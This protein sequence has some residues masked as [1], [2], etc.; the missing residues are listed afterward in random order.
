[1][2]DQGKYA[3]D[4]D[5]L[6]HEYIINELKEFFVIGNAVEV[7]CYEGHMT[8]LLTPHFSTLTVVEADKEFAKKV[9]KRLPAV[10]AIH[11]RIEDFPLNRKFDNAF[12][13]HTL[14]HIKNDVEVLATL[15]NLL[16]ERGRLFVVVPNATAGSRQIAVAAGLIENPYGIT[17]SEREHGHLRTYDSRTLRKVVDDVGLKVIASGGIFF[18]ALANFQLDA[19]M[20]SG[21]I[22]EEYL[23]GCLLLSKR[24]PDLCSS[25]YAVCES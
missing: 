3:Y 6:M 8:E 18:K 17:D 16:S 14:E 7:G 20:K 5:Y 15:G 10:E 22:G 21:V 11:S 4:F 24:Y 2:T 23:R 1:M 19:S 12:I 13:V 9:S 25:I